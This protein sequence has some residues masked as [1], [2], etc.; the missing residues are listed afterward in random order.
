MNKSKGTTMNGLSILG[1]CL[2]I[3][4]VLT[5][6]WGATLFR[7]NLTDSRFMSFATSGVI[8][9]AIGLCFISAVPPAV[10]VAG[11]WA[12]TLTTMIYIWWLPKMELPVRIISFVPLV[13]FAV[14]LTTKLLK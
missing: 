14:W 9:A 4:G 13:A 3:V 2:A 10:S 12:A 8:L 11:I 6:I 7:P 5:V 1:Y